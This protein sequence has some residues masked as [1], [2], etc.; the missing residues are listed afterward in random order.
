MLVNNRSVVE[1]IVKIRLDF[2]D[3]TTKE[4]ILKKGNMG[5]FV[6]RHNDRL[7]KEFGKVK[8]II[9]GT[10]YRMIHNKDIDVYYIVLDTSHKFKSEEY[11]ICLN[12]LVDIDLVPD[13][14]VIGPNR[15]K[16][17]MKVIADEKG[18]RRYKTWPVLR[19][20]GEKK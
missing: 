2:D 1:H 11:K 13:I 8:N 7:I 5:H 15:G 10:N 4:C 19:P 12:D 9:H 20:R 6:F 17:S 3:G 14:E 18:E 16:L